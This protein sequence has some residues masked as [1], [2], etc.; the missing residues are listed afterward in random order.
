MRAD[1]HDGQEPDSSNQ[2]P[3]TLMQDRYR[4]LGK[5]PL[6][7]HGR[8][9]HWVRI[10]HFDKAFLTSCVDGARIARV[11]LMFLRFGRVPSCVRPFGAVVMTAGPDGVRGGGPILLFEL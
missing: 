4:Q 6:A 10:G 1:I 5:N 11:D 3:D 8:T 7:T 2:R 9:I